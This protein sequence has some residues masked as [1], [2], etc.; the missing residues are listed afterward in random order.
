MLTANIVTIPKP[1]K[2]PVTPQNFDPISLLNTDLNLYARIVAQRLAPIMPQLI[3]SDQ[4]GFTLGRQAPDATR[5][6]TNLLYFT[7]IKQTPTIFLTLDSEKGF[8][9]IH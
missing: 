8:D 2:E 5:K 7:E 4:V 6:I 3:H 1:G 9:S